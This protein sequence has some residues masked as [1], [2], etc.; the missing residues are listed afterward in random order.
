MQRGAERCSDV[1]WVVPHPHV[2]DK[3]RRDTLGA[4]D[5]TPDLRAPGFQ[6]QEDKFP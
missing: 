3:I 5:P 6:G 1:K 2:V 4:R